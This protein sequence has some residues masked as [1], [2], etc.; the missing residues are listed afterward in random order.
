MK[1]SPMAKVKGWF[2]NPSSIV[3]K[4]QLNNKKGPNL[5]TSHSTGCFVKK[6]CDMLALHKNQDGSSS[7]NMGSSG[8]IVI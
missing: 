3:G 7:S 2:L 6:E 1:S 5:S 4:L 8:Q